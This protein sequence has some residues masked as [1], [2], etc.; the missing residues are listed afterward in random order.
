[1]GVAIDIICVTVSIILL[2]EILAASA[3]LMAV[4]LA[5]A[6]GGGLLLAADGYAYGQEMMD[7]EAGAEE[8]KKQTEL[9]RIFATVMTLPDLAYG[10]YK[11][12]G[13]YREVGELLEADERTAQAAENIGQ[14]T[15]KA[16]RAKR[17]EQIAERTHLRAQIR[18]EKLAASRKLELLPRAAGGGGAGL[19][20]REEINNRESLLHE[21]AKRL[22]IH[23]TTVHKAAGVK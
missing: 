5:A 20:T 22:R 7:D 6:A 16:D 11:A 4:S 15:A 14:R 13:E 8:T 18:A 10:G 17:Y 19:L 2:P 3:G 23:A 9:L 1:L 12:V 21:V